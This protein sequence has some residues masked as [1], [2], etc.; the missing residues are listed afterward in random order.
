[1]K[2]NIT[3]L[4][5]TCAIV[6]GSAAGDRSVGAVPLLIDI[7]RAGQGAA[8]TPQDFAAAGVEENLGGATVA[9]V[10]VPSTAGSSFG[11]AGLVFTFSNP[12]N[13]SY[14][15]SLLGS[16]EHTSGNALLDSYVYLNSLGSGPGPV[17]VTISGLRNILSPQTRYRFYLFGTAG[18]D[19]NQN[20]RF[21][22]LP[23]GITKTTLVPGAMSAASVSFYFTTGSVVSNSIAFT[24]A[25]VGTDQYS[26]FNGIAITVAQFQTAPIPK[27]SRIAKVRGAV[28]IL[29]DGETGLDYVLETS[30]DLKTWTPLALTPVVE[31]NDWEF[32]DTNRETGV[33]SRFYRI[34]AQLPS[35]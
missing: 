2:L 3:P 22:F 33:G 7:M 19:Q 34:K 14:D 24:W 16:E 15:V 10:G 5:L 11:A 32:I 26:A 29:F 25:R 20:A 13:A 21:T 18:S 27:I 17:T 4:A 12:Y 6:W 1:M 31:Q 28:S 30:P 9:R 35:K 23:G 8:A